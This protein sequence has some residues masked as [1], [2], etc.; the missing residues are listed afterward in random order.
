M[1]LFLALTAQAATPNASFVGTWL[2]DKDDVKLVLTEKEGSV[3]ADLVFMGD[4]AAQGVLEGDGVTRSAPLEGC[5]GDFTM[6]EAGLKLVL[7]GPEC[8]VDF[9]GDYVKLPVS[10]CGAKTT[11]FSCTAKKGKV[12]SVC[13]A[14]DKSLSYAY[15]L[16][17]KVELALEGGA[18]AERSLASGTEYTWGFTNEGHSYSVFVVEARPQDTGA[19]ILIEKGGEHVAT[20]ACVG[21]WFKR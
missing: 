19:G 6:T 21:D 20:V 7:D 13:E 1:L 15:G 17:E 16:P 11:R 14:A 3:H 12:I 4:S 5:G 18:F 9:N 10:H 2:N 8:P